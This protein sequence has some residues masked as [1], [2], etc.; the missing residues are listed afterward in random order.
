MATTTQS[1]GSGAPAV[2]HWGQQAS[3]LADAALPVLKLGAN[4][5][6]TIAGNAL[7]QTPSASPYAAAIDVSLAV[8]P[9]VVDASSN[10]SVAVFK[11][12]VNPSANNPSS[13]PSSV[14]LF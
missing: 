1:V 9:A 2:I 11:Q 8:S 10:A 6:I 5:A 14:S 13:M 7:K 4:V 12:V 3:Q